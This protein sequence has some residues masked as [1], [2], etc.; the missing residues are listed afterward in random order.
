MKAAIHLYRTQKAGNTA[1]ENEDASWPRASSE[2]QQDG[3]SVRVA[4]ADGATSSAFSQVWSRLLVRDFGKRDLNAENLE[5]RLERLA[6][7]WKRAVSRPD[8]PWSVKAKL[9][10]G[11][12]A[13]FVGLE[14]REGDAAGRG[15]GRWSGIACG[16]SVLFHLRR[17]QP[18]T[19]FPP[20][21]S[22]DFL[23]APYLLGT[24]GERR[25]AGGLQSAAGE[26]CDGDR[27]YLMTDALARWFLL[28][29][30]TGSDPWQ[31][32]P[33][34]AAFADDASFAEWIDSLRS[35]REI[36]NDDCT[37]MVVTPVAS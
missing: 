9:R 33:R 34:V 2:L 10:L 4:I 16:D 32:L 17:G 13:A 12:F 11:S 27:F 8:A 25:G 15:P 19:V 23:N 6:K 18:L 21:T 35:R 22:A 26:W 24:T 20:L 36:K 30:E 7:V 29:T 14:L 37:L 28:C 1:S 5:Q 3:R 31:G